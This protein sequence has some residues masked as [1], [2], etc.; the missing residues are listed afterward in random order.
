MNHD[1]E[2]K[3]IMP[4]NGKYHAARNCRVPEGEGGKE[5][6]RKKKKKKK[7]RKGNNRE[8]TLMETKK[9]TLN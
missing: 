9:I 3:N 5:K 4:E 1:D 8:T 6:K 2:K 7:R